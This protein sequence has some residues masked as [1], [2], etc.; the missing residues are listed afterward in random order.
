MEKCLNIQ[1][2]IYVCTTIIL[3]VSFNFENNSE[4]KSL[5]QIVALLTY[6]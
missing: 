1:I 5:N 3:Y 2:N 4:N 6:L